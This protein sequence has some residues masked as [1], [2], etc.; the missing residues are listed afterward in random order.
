MGAIGI[1]A[2]V[3]VVVIAYFVMTGSAS[4]QAI[5]NTSGTTYQSS[6]S[7]ITGAPITQDQSTWPSS[8]NYWKM[9]CAIALAEGYNQGAGV[10]P[11]D[12]NN[13]GDLTDD[14]SQY[15]SGT[16][17]ITTFPTAE[18][19][20]QALYSKLQNIVSGG[21]SVYPSDADWTDVGNTW[22]GGD[23][24]WATNVAANLGVDPSTTPAQ[25]A[26]GS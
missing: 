21:S 5:P 19:G 6:D 11:Y 8:D 17:G 13:P 14:A 4:A 15:G 20:W 24:N 1:I 3:G 25:Y 7:S 26:L 23:A 9:C 16:N 18:A 22:S 10:I 12:Y 2:V